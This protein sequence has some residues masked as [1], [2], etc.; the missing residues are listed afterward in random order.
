[1]GVAKRNWSDFVIYTPQGAMVERVTFDQ[2]YREK[3][4]S[5]AEYFYSQHVAGVLV[6]KNIQERHIVPRSLSEGT[7]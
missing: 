7:F 4:V 6:T 2:Q 5:A 1:M 3:L